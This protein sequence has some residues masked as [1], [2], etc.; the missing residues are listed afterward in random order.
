MRKPSAKRRLYNLH[1]WLGF[2]L[3][4]L[5]SLVLLTGTIAVFSDEIDWLIQEDMR[6]TPGETM[7]GWGELDR[8]VREAI[9]EGHDIVMMQSSGGDRTAWRFLVSRTD[10][11]PYFVNVD[12]WTGKITGTSST[13]TVQ[14]FLRDLHRYL[15]MP[16]V[17]GLPIVGSL[18]FVLLLSTYTGLKTAGR[19]RT[20]AMRLRTDRGS[21]I[22]VGDAHKAVGIWASWFVLLI[23]ITGVW[24]LA[25]LISS[26]AD[27]PF[28]PGRPELSESRLAE[29]GENPQV[30]SADRIIRAASAQYDSWVPDVIIYPQSETGVVM[31]TGRSTDPLVRTRANSVFIDP[32]DGSV[33][34]TRRSEELGAIAYL[35]ELADPLHFGDVGGL[36]TQIIWFGFGVGL[37]G[38]SITGV[39]LTYR[40]LKGV[41]VSKTQI[42]TMPV[43]LATVIAGYFYID[44]HGPAEPI[45]NL[46][47][48]AP[49]PFPL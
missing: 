16:G 29:I 15:F 21:R 5:M 2:H 43:L 14:R 11:T 34:E 19:L 24:Y 7:A 46:A 38:L 1:A 48:A 37:T 18:G 23:A 39:W 4:L 30:V 17:I 26:A 10:A 25:E 35:N 49:T 47:V 20:T 12:Q 40:R 27:A 31:V 45:A 6:V 32:Y 8:S 22:L 9:P 28:E 42:V 36:T 41:L 33:I 44:G 3:A 13:L